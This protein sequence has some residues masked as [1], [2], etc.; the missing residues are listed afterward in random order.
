MH[1][2]ALLPVEIERLVGF[3]EMVM[4]TDLHWP[5]AGIDDPQSYLA[6]SGVDLDVAVTSDDFAGDNFVVGALLFSWPDRVMDGDE[7]GSI[8]EGALD[9]N[10]RHQV[11]NAR[12]YV[13]R[14]K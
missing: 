10:H 7:L 9:L 11:G 4:A 14:R 12:H 2:E 3:E 6:P 8:R 13:V 5:V 1:A